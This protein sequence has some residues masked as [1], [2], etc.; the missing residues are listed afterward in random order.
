VG[1]RNVAAQHAARDGEAGRLAV[2]A[3]PGRFRVELT[4]PAETASEGRIEGRIDGV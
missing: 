2:T 3:P 1:L 4:L